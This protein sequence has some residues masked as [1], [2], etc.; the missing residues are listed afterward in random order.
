VNVRFAVVHVDMNRPETM[1]VIRE[2]VRGTRAVTEGKSGGGSQYTKQIKQGERARYWRFHCF[3][4]PNEH[5][6]LPPHRIARVDRRP[7]ASRR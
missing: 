6:R 3:G 4:Q 7:V 2:A 1:I 5:R